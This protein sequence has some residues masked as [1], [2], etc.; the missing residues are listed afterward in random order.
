LSE[1][2]T[3][4]AL[5]AGGVLALAVIAA[6]AAIFVLALIIAFLKTAQLRESRKRYRRARERFA[7][8]HARRR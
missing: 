8:R 5:G 7:G 6:F 2:Q 1:Y 4:L 3:L